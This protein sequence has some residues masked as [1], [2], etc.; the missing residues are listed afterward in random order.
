MLRFFV[1]A[2]RISSRAFVVALRTVWTAMQLFLFENNT[3]AWYYIP[4]LLL[5]FL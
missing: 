4:C 5:L 2:R 3:G 1:P